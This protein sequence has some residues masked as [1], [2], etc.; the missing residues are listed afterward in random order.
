MHTPSKMLVI[1]L[2]IIINFIGE[3]TNGGDWET[4]RKIFCEPNFINN[5]KN[6]GIYIYIYKILF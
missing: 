5:I 4:M 2:E 6:I 3:D 1:C